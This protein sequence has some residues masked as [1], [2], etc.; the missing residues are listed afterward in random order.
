MKDG[1]YRA[2]DSD[3]RFGLYLMHGACMRKYGFGVPIR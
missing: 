1:N 2:I 3:G